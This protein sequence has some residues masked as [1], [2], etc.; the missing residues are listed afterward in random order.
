M[1]TMS[2]KKKILIFS[3]AYE[4]LVGGA[5]IA[6]REITDRLSPD[7]FDFHMVTVRVAGRPRIE[8][9]GHIIVHRVSWSCPGRDIISRTL[10]RLG[11]YWFPYAAARYGAALHRAEQFDMAWSIMAAFAGFAT[12]FFHK[13]TNVPY[14][15]TLQ[16]G[17]P[18]EH[19]RR[20]VKPV[21]PWFKNMF[22][23]AFR[24]HAISHY[25]ASFAKEEGASVEPV[26]IGNGVDVARF[27]ASR[28]LNERVT[29]R[30]A[31]GIQDNEQVMFTAS[32]L[33]KKNAVDVVIQALTMLPATTKLV[34]AGE[35]PL[36]EELARLANVLKVSSR[37]LFLGTIPH[38]QLP[39]WFHAADVFVRPS[40][41]EGFGNVFAEAMAA[42]APVIATGVGGIPDIVKDNETGL[43][44]AVDD[45]Q[46][47]AHKVKKILTEPAL[48]E[49]LV[50]R[51]KAMVQDHYTW[52]CVA[53]RMK[54]EVFFT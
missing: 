24:V 42:G 6:V 33:V 10:H 21:Y 12:L 16:E 25:L 26:V 19:I 20:M 46:D 40:R 29:I 11:K 43:V 22:K 2:R 30:H 37:V 14:I 53:R 15:L 18:P 50:E 38:E 49:R 8:Y 35:G 39:M 32:R 4:P 28:P 31:R 1:H 48:R 27:G 34:V 7:E 45:P 9:V 51:G 23:Y 17:D 5:E 47:L 13:K 36:R 52:D 44:C 41:S 54:E 3:Y